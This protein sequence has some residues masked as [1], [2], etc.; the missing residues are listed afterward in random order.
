MTVVKIV[1][2]NGVTAGTYTYD[3]DAIGAHAVIFD[4]Q[5]ESFTQLQI[6]QLGVD[7]ASYDMILHLSRTAA[8]GR[9]SPL[10]CVPISGAQLQLIWTGSGAATRAR[11]T[12]LNEAQQWGAVQIL[13]GNR[14]VAAATTDEPF[15]YTA[16]ARAARDLIAS[17]SMTKAGYFAVAMQAIGQTLGEIKR[18]TL[19]DANGGGVTLSDLPALYSYKFILRNNDGAAA[20]TFAYALWAR[21]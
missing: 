12:F 7:A 8:N 14:S 3:V 16:R 21:L 17:S 6:N 19:T 2:L 15:T 11:L 5:N 18:E 20:S 4:L 1:D 9:G 10:F 13:D